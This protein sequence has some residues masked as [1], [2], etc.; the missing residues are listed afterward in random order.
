M[1]TLGSSKNYCTLI[2]VFT[3][4]PEKSQELFDLLIIGLTQFDL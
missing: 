2:N 3:V 4:A 1:T